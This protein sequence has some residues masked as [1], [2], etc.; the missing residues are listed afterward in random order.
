VRADGILYLEPFPAHS[1]ATRGSATPPPSAYLL[2]VSDW[3]EGRAL[4]VE[5]VCIA[6]QLSPDRLSFRRG[7]H[8]ATTSAS[9]TLADGAMSH[10]RSDPDF[11]MYE[12]SGVLRP[13]VTAYLKGKPMTAKDIAAMRTYLRVWIFAPEFDGEGVE[14][15]RQMVD[16]LASREAIED[17]LATARKE[18][19]S[20]L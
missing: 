19:V 9:Y 20:P 18:W 3:T 4:R 13:A 6:R 15:L 14:A 17:W 8:D 10:S 2:G 5:R 11:W 12:T 1:R 16:G 7:G